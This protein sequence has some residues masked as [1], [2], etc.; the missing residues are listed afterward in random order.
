VKSAT[1][2]EGLREGEVVGE[3]SIVC[4]AIVNVYFIRHFFCAQDYSALGAL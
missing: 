3:L 4:M 1:V 2:A